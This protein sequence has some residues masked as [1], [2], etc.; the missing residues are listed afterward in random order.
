MTQSSN[1]SIETISH[2]V[3]RALAS[4]KKSAWID[5]RRPIADTSTDHS[6]A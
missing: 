5:A 4:I 6:S 2:P 1:G 3:D